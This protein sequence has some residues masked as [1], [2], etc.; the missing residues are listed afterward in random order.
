MLLK[1]HFICGRIPDSPPEP[2][3]RSRIRRERHRAH[4]SVEHGKPGEQN[5][6]AH[7]ALLRR[8]PCAGQLRIHSVEQ[9]EK[10]PSRRRKLCLKK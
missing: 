5:V 1:I 7:G 9:N 10:T 2:V 3:L 4:H 8:V 6:S